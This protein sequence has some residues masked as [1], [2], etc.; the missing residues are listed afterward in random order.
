[1]FGGTEI[2]ADRV[3][4][5]LSTSEGADAVMMLASTEEGCGGYGC[6]VVDPWESI[7]VRCFG[8]PRLEPGNPTVEPA[9]VASLLRL[10]FVFDGTD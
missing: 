4:G 2:V 5:A 9:A 10:G 3:L 8:W 1:M 7:E 6:V